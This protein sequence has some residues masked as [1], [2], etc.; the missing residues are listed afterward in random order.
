MYKKSKF[1]FFCY[2]DQKEL[3]LYNCY[4]GMKS[5]CKIKDT[6][7]QSI[8]LN[9][10]I[11]ENSSL[12]DSLYK[13]GYLV[14]NDADENS[15]LDLLINSV[16]SPNDLKLVFS[17]TENCNFR[18]KYCYESHQ[19][20]SISSDL[21]DDLILYVRNN[22]Q[23]VNELSISWFGGE[24][25]MEKEL[26]MDMS[27]KLIR[28]CNFNKRRYSAFITTNGYLLDIK[29]FEDLLK[30][31][32]NIFQITV[33][34]VEST[35]NYN[36][37]FVN[38]GYTFEKIINNL[39][40]IKKSKNKNFHIII[41]TNVTYEIYNNIEEYITL[42]S[43]L[44][45]GDDRFSV[46]IHYA[47]AWNPEIEEDFKLKIFNDRDN[48]LDFYNRLIGS[49]RKIKFT[50]MIDPQNASCFYASKNRFFIRPNGEIHVCSVFS[51]KKENIIG[52]LSNGNISLKDNYFSKIIDPKSCKSLYSCFYAPVCKG[53]ICPS[54]RENKQGCPT[55]KN[56]LDYIL[57][58]IDLRGDLQIIG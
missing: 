14:S 6:N 30:C 9:G 21:R 41:R 54:E 31:R 20:I 28:I 29:T 32:I 24:P 35:H 11:A 40:E 49:K 36:R 13:R 8:F 42:I 27:E 19:N 53:D 38:G 18:C 5:L 39:N 45:E 23:K 46:M 15:K 3:L 7:N 44:C 4:Q 33:D 10:N 17:V 56:H 34:G 37:P 26:I 58:L 52:Y 57:K 22:I 25:L 12:Q 43:N 2:N 1:N 48:V 47:S 50:F 55:T 51:E 16:I